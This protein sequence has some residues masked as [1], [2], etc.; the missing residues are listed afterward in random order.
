MAYFFF[1]CLT[2]CERNEKKKTQSS[3]KSKWLTKF[4]HFPFFNVDYVHEFFIKIIANGNVTTVTDYIQNKYA[5]RLTNKTGLNAKQ[6]NLSTPIWIWHRTI[7]DE[8]F[9]KRA[10]NRGLNISAEWINC[11]VLFGKKGVEIIQ[12]RWGESESLKYVNRHRTL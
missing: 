3:E 12:I 2:N 1:R 11:I 4:I 9:S 7:F 6:L 10:T 8:Y 5:I